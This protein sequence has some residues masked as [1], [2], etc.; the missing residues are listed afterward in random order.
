MIS[1][2]PLV[3]HCGDQCTFDRGVAFSFETV[4]Q[5]ESGDF[6]FTGTLKQLYPGA[7]DAGDNAV[8]RV[9]DRAFGAFH[10]LMQLAFVFV[11][12]IDGGVQRTFE[13]QCTQFALHNC[14]PARSVI[15]RNQVASTVFHD[16]LYGAFVR[17]RLHRNDRHLGMV[18]VFLPDNLAH[19]IRIAV[20]EQNDEFDAVAA[21]DLVQLGRVG[22]PLAV[23]CMA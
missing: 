19:F 2:R 9:G 15:R 13:A 21:Q 8:L 23:G 4:H 5:G 16:G 12:G 11:G 20:F 1:G 3:F 22:C 18:I 7:V 14:Q 17:F 10:V 6:V